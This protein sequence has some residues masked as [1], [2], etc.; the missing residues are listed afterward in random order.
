MQEVSEDQN[1]S[2]AIT[3]R[4]PVQFHKREWG[5]CSSWSTASNAGKTCTDYADTQVTNEICGNR[6]NLSTLYSFANR[7]T[8][9][10]VSEEKDEEV[11][12]EKVDGLKQ[13]I[14]Q[15][16]DECEPAAKN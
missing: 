1:R 3:I 15:T 14:Q 5:L 6:C 13:R 16:L 10:M 9:E 8:V 4:Q 7:W 2:F 12:Y 11:A